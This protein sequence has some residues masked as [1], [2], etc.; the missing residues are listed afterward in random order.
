M[1]DLELLFLILALLYVWEC[2]CWVRRGSV[3]F[4]TWLGTQWRMKHPGTLLGNQLGGFI[5]GAPLPPLGTILVGGQLPVSLSPEGALMFVAPAVNPGWRPPQSAA[6]CGMRELGKARP[7]GKKV[8]V[9]GVVLLRP[10]STTY[11]QFLAKRLRA[12]AEAAEGKRPSFLEELVRETLDERLVR[13]R[14]KEFQAQARWLRFVTNGLFVYV[15]VVAPVLIWQV[16]LG[17]CWA[18]L[19]AGLLGC[20]ASTAILFRNGHR[21]LY[22]EDEEERFTHSLIVLLSPATAMRACDL[23]SRPLMESFHPLALARVLCPAPQFQRYARDIWREIRYPALPLCPR[24][25]PVAERIE[26]DWRTVL[27]GEVEQFLTRNGIDPGT[28]LKP[29][30]Q[31]DPACLAYCPRCGAQYTTRVGVCDDCGGRALMPFGEGS[32]PQR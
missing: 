2:A 20:T 11:T 4:R 28:L 21:R 10:Q 9:N 17:Q 29:P 15:F 7:V 8:E 18:I 24:S 30:E 5:F 6:L 19:L 23:L 31:T 25:E 1:T 13:D 22:P 16:G 14:L 27:S 3:V 32:D 26:R 12:L